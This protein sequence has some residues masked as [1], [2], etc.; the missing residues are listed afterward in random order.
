MDKSAKTKNKRRVDERI[1]KFPVKGESKSVVYAC[2]AEALCEKAKAEGKIQDFNMYVTGIGRNPGVYFK[3]IG[4]YG[5]GTESNYHFYADFAADGTYIMICQR[6]EDRDV[7]AE[8]AGKFFKT[9]PEIES[10]TGFV[11]DFIEAVSLDWT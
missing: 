8:W 3:V 9:S 7:S 2:L 6:D 4:T 1:V 10:C 11:Y 5:P